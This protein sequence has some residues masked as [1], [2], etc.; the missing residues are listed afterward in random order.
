MKTRTHKPLTHPQS[1][2]KGQAV[3]EAALLS[4][5]LAALLAGAVDLG[6]AFYTATVVTNMAGE[7]AAYAALYPYQDTSDQT[8]SIFQPV[9]VSKSI[10]E[11]ARRVAKDHGLTIEKNDQDLANITITTNGYGSSC[12]VRCAG[13]TVTV[14][15]TYTL[16]DLF[17]PAFLGMRNIRITK[18]ASQVIVGNLEKNGQCST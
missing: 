5:I 12:S 11:R 7:G 14:Q 18:S 1:P 13:R 3:V 9:A 4:L 8:C 16:D 17:L 2:R 15:V 6:R 10:Q